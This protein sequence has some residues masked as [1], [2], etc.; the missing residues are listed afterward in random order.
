M[1][2]YRCLG[3]QQDLAGR[4][5]EVREDN[6]RAAG[7]FFRPHGL[8]ADDAGNLTSRTRATMLFAVSDPTGWTPFCGGFPGRCGV[9]AGIEERLR[10]HRNHRVLK[11]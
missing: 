10:G 5:R 7:P 4:G 11:A 3:F 1:V 2:V 9:C 8:A 6:P